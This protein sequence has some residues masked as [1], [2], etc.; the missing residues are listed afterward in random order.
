RFTYFKMR[1]QML[2]SQFN[3]KAAGGDASV[4]ITNEFSSLGFLCECVRH[5]FLLLVKSPLSIGDGLHSNDS[6]LHV[7]RRGLDA[8]WSRGPCSRY[9]S[10]GSRVDASTST[11]FLSPVVPARACQR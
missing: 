7:S 10:T 11:P 8:I 2:D 5:W 4:T 6:S 1:L 3:P 9:Q